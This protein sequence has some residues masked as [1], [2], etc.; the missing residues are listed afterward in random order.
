[1]RINFLAGACAGKSTASHWL[2]SELK[3]HQY[4][5]EFA[6]EYIKKFTYLGVDPATLDQREI[7]ENQLE[8][9]IVPLNGGVKNIV[10]ESPVHLSHLYARKNGNVAL[11]N[12]IEDF[13][14]SFDLEH[15]SILIYLERGDKPYNPEGRWGTIEDAKKMDELIKEF[16]NTQH[17]KWGVPV[18]Y[19]HYKNRQEI[20]DFTL[21]Y[22]D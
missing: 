6:R 18:L 8:E 14:E 16:V 7:F 11:A 10:S 17:L 12:E 3:D 21:E 19:T 5:V 20:L 4:S 2:F 15:K 22:I 9:E 1:M 13:C